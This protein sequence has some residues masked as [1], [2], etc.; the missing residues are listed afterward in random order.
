MKKKLKKLTPMDI[1]YFFILCLPILD[2]ISSITRRL[3][4]FSLS[5][6]MIVK[7][8]TL[9]GGVLYVLFKSKSKFKRPAIIFM[10]MS[11]IYVLCYFGFKIDLIKLSY[12]K[13]E[14]TYLIKFFFFPVTFF[15]LLNLYDD[16][17]FDGK[18][19]NK[20]LLISTLLYIVL[21]IV[22][23][24][25]GL[26]FNSYINDYAGSVGWYYSANEVSTILL[27]LFPFIYTLIEGK[28]L[29]L[30]IIFALNLYTISLI[31][32]KVTLFGIIIVSIIIFLCALFY[33]KKRNY[34]NAL[35]TFLLLAVVVIVMSNNYSAMNLKSALSQD[36]QQEIE[37]LKDKIDNEGIEENAFLMFTRKCFGPLLSHRDVY[38]VNTYN[39]FMDNYRPDYIFFGMG[40]SITDRIDDYYV[41]K[42]IEIDVL[43]TMFH[44]GFVAVI[45]WMTPFIYALCIFIKKKVKITVQ[46]FF[47][48]MVILLTVGISIFAGH[49][50]LAPAVSL[51]VALYFSYLFESGGCF[52]TKNGIELK[53]RITFLNLH[54]GM[55]GI[56]TAT[57]ESANALSE[58]YDVEI[59]ACYKMKN[60]QSKNLNK[61]VGVRYLYDGEPNRDEFL[62]N[63]RHLKLFKTFMEGLK[64]LHILYLKKY[65][66]IHAIERC[67]SK[68]IVST[69]WEFSV[70]LSKYKNPG[71]VAIAEE[72][73]HHNDRKKYIDVIKNRYQNID[74]LFALTTTLQ[75]D[76]VEF[77]KGY[78]THTKVV[79]MPNMLAVDE[80]HK[81]SPLTKK[82]LISVGRLTSI[83]R[84][85]EMISLFA[86]L[87]N[88]DTKLFIIG[89]GELKQE[90]QKEV[91]DLNLESRVI[92]TGFLDKKAQSKYYLDSCL[93]LM[94][95]ITEGLPMVLLEANS[96][97]IPAVA[98]ETKSGIQDIIDDGIDGYIIKDRNEEEFIDKVDG[99][100][101][102]DKLLQKFSKATS[103]AVKRYNRESVLKMWSSIIDEHF[104]K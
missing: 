26:N 27:L 30:Y 19:M 80:K 51:Y 70:L 88:K 90:L 17:G 98:Y 104:T 14:M 55:G 96:Y 37:K 49:V 4:G 77:L 94:T 36:Q 56:E 84:I 100:L 47:F 78:N 24:I 32:T 45:L 10:A 8:I 65:G 83:K 102:D 81:K 73:L 76:Y 87:K 63:L 23:T 74:Y 40:F 29:I 34:K 52:K 60:D 9:L 75:K 79:H 38:A 64:S 72:H 61:K 33:S 71:V 99:L 1:F 15:T 44:M 68:I 103:K 11:F 97:G 86:K 22:P 50:Y 54:L 69:Q 20:L 31:G 41:E 6:G 58:K 7:G 66:M 92:F 59:I 16:Y 12:L 21:I 18:K 5:L 91:E 93:F 67:D 25:L 13:S 2:L 42:L 35:I 82:N 28:K 89:D 85:D 95:S 62:D 57:I 48:T 53:N 43:D 39:I 46:V 101:S 3:T